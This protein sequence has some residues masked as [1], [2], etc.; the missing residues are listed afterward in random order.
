MKKVVICTKPDYKYLEEYIKNTLPEYTL[1]LYDENT[2][3]LE[4]NI[5]Y[6][7]IRL[8]PFT[9]KSPEP[10]DFPQIG[11]MVDYK[12]PLLPV[13]SKIGFLNTEHCT[14]TRTLQYVKTYLLPNMDIFD[15][16]EDNCKIMRK[17]THLPYKERAEETRKLQEFMKLPKRYHVC[18]VGNTS[19]RRQTIV[20]ILRKKRLKLKYI[21][22]SFGDK[23]DRQIGMSHLLLNIHLHEEWKIYESIRCER[24]RFA[25]MKIVS[26]TS[27]SPHPEGIITSK[28]EDLV[29]T[30]CTELSGCKI[31]EMY[32][33][34]A[35]ED[36][37]SEI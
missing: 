27:F 24:W 3:F 36:A 31:D 16:S 13:N 11:L 22:N 32:T 25:G 28:Y 21:T 37:T 33:T 8:I 9:L 23:R 17:G 26:E 19:G 29:D 12:C 20:D 14:D 34:T 30:V 2:I 35:A 6:L 10:T 1:F 4:E 5:Y 15:Y 18:I 7:S